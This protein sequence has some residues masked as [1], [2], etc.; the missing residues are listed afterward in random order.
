MSWKVQH[1]PTRT[2]VG[3]RRMNNIKEKKKREKEL[4]KE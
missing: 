2:V 1:T 3:R 4:A